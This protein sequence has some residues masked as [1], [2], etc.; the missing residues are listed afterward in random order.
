ME[1]ARLAIDGRLR[2]MSTPPADRFRVILQEFPE[3]WPAA[4]VEFAEGEWWYAGPGPKRDLAL[5]T[6][7]MTQLV[8]E[9]IQRN[10]GDRSGRTV[11]RT[12]TSMPRIAHYRASGPDRKADP[13]LNGAGLPLNEA[14]P[15]LILT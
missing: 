13:H 2:P 11:A 1:E 4:P 12:R 15:D 14:A 8:I 7:Q 9:Q 10:L 6:P 3:L 5:G